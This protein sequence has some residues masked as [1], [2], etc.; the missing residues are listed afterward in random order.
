METSLNLSFT[1]QEIGKRFE[2]DLETAFR[3]MQK[4]FGFKW[5]RFTDTHEAGNVVRE[6][7]ADY[8]VATPSGLALVEAKASMM[9]NRFRP[10]LLRPAQKGAIRHYAQM[11]GVPYFVLF[12]DD[13]DQ[14]VDLLNGKDCLEARPVP[15][16]AFKTT[17]LAD[18]LAEAWALRPLRSTLQMFR[19]R[20]GGNE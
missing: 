10:S 17:A 3:G 19:Q 12:R 4:E 18:A 7:P 13:T 2:R 5:H 15:L 16:R 11:L 6:Q 20:Y 1:S 8:L 14:R 9:L